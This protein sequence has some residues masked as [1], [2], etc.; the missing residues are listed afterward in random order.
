MTHHLRT[1]CRGCG[2]HSFERFLELGPTPL[3]NSFLRSPADAATEPSYPLDVYLCRDCSLVQLLDVIDAE[4]LFR[5]YIYVTGTSETMA[6]HNVGYAEDVVSSLGLGPDSLVVEVASNDGSLLARFADHGV[7]ILGVEPARNIAALAR[8]AGIETVDEFFDADLG[9]SL[10]AERGSAAVVV[11]NNVLA[12]VDDPVGFLSGARELIDDDGHVVTEFPYL[13]DFLDHLEYDTVY[14]EHLSYFSVI[15]LMTLYERA[16]LALTR[17]DRR[18][19]HGGSLRVYAARRTSRR[20]AHAESVVA[21][22]DE[23]RRKGYDRADTYHA[24][25]RRV[26]AQRTAL[27]TLL[28]DAKAA[29][30][31]IAAYGAPAKGNTMLN[32]C[33]IGNDVLDFVTDKSPH[34]VGRLTP[35]SHIPVV[36]A[37]SLVE[38]RPDLVLILAWNFADE[39]MRQQAEYTRNGG[40][41]VLPIPEPRIVNP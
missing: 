11:A 29:G 26:A 27:R 34:K 40:R 23:E 28:L 14:H 6:R 21:L 41:F 13:G 22:S 36:D 25:A 2:G 24:F 20:S 4:T 18:P 19:V 3:A 31:R 1:T 9:R 10:R 38:R 35:G 33:G 7:R 16:G 32:Y 17:I 30:K 12:H 8:A 39:I 37:A 15:A 5:D